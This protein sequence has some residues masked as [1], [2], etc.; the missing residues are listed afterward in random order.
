MKIFA[1]ASLLTFAATIATAQAGIC[2]K[3]A[4][5]FAE[6]GAEQEYDKGGFETLDCALAPNKK[7]MVCNVGASQG[8]G[9]V[10]DMLRVVMNASCT[11][12]LRV[13]LISE[14]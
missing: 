9:A 14:E 12:A 13:E 5:I 7:V 11:R 10:V 3:N 8:D 6:R 4:E 2:E 1:L